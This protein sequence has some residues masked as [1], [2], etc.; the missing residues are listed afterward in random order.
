MKADLPNGAALAVALLAAT[1]GVGWRHEAT[2]PTR[3]VVVG[4]AALRSDATE[5][6]DERGNAVAV[7]PYRRILSLNSVADHLLLHLVEPDRIVG[8]TRTSAEQHPESFRFAGRP[9]LSRADELEGVL[10]LAP[11]LVITSRFSDESLLQRLRDEGIAVFDLGEM[12]GVAST[13]DDLR[14][15]GVLLGV[16]DR[17]DRVEAT[18]RM[19]LAALDAAV[20]AADAAP[21]IYMSIY[22]DRIYGGTRGT[23]YAD[24]LHL[25]GVHDLAAE[26][27]F[28]DWPA[29]SP[30]QLLQLDPP[31]IVTQDGMGPVI[32]GHSTLRQLAACREGGRVVEVPG[33]YHSDP[34]LGLVHAAHAVLG[35]VH[36]GV[37]AWPDDVTPSLAAARL[38]SPDTPSPDTPSPEASPGASR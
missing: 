17:A 29:Y 31:L 12:R 27:G 11:D 24:M 26:H 1:A 23:S 4:A 34:G 10:G 28:V 32:C 19:Q 15:L 36:P 13:I 38:P 9:G 37:S 5:V 25:A 35:L 6:V 2:D 18:F 14:R 16:Q 3:T 20:P 33:Q 30:E 21:G 22:G 7:A 8:V